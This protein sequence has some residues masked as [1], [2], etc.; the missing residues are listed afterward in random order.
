MGAFIAR[1]SGRCAAE[2]GE[3]IAAGDRVLFVDDE[4]V[5]E[6]C[7]LEG[8]VGADRRHGARREAE[9]CT[10]CYL[11]RPCPCDDGGSAA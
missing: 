1:W 8:L 3:P 10:R 4:L 2:C 11:I 9:V 5:H 6:G 7:E